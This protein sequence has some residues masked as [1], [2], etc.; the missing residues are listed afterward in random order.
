MNFYLFFP[1]NSNVSLNSQINEAIMSLSEEKV[2][3]EALEPA[4]F[5][6]KYKKSLIPMN[7][8][9]EM[10]ILLGI[11][12]AICIFCHLIARF[13][14]KK[15]KFYEYL[16]NKKLVNISEELKKKQSIFVKKTRYVFSFESLKEIIKNEV[17]KIASEI[18]LRLEIMTDKINRFY[19]M[20]L[21]A[22]KENSHI[23]VDFDE[24]I[25]KK[26]KKPFTFPSITKGFKKSSAISV[27][28]EKA[29]KKSLIK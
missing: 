8:I 7:Y 2:T 27:E 21:I 12:L 14:L 23:E 10:L 25:N 29:R 15:L 6:R 19:D 4:I 16:V 11:C 24:K 13:W 5:N 22:K 9:D 28:K 26:F 17:E 1:E 18:T 20:I 3:Y